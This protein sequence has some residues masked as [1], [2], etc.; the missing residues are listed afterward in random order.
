MRLVC[1]WHVTDIQLCVPHQRIT[2]HHIKLRSTMVPSICKLTVRPFRFLF[3]VTLISWISR[4]PYAP[5]VVITRPDQWLRCCRRRIRR[6][7]ATLVSTAW[8]RSA[9]HANQAP[10]QARARRTISPYPLAIW[11]MHSVSCSP[12][13]SHH[14]TSSVSSCGL[15]SPGIGTT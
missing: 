3:S 1:R 10:A 13:A 15:Q 8:R 14:S 2:L 9:V 11:S 12:C 7:S 6:H 4:N 5:D